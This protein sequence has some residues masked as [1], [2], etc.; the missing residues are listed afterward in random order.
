M[1][2][3]AQAICLKW[4]V[5]AR[6]L[7]FPMSRTS[8]TCKRIQRSTPSIPLSLRPSVRAY[9]KTNPGFPPAGR[10]ALCQAL[11]N[12]DSS[13]YWATSE[14]CR[15]NCNPRPRLSGP[16]RR[17]R[18]FNRCGTMVDDICVNDCLG[19]RLGLD[20]SRMFMDLYDRKWRGGLL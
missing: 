4:S 10:V 17:N 11:D 15:K 3:H 9:D 2:S 13:P 20:R 16:I 1:F 5:I 7:D 14:P 18:M 6:E 19:A 12:G 8:N